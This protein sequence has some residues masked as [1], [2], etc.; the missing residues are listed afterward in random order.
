MA[1]A[2]GNMILISSYIEPSGLILD[3]FL[4]T[5]NS[6]EFAIQITES[7]YE[8]RYD[9]PEVVFESFSALSDMNVLSV[10]LSGQAGDPLCGLQLILKDSDN[11]VEILDGL[12][13]ATG[14]MHMSPGGSMVSGPTID[15]PFIIKKGGTYGNSIV[16]VNSLNARYTSSFLMTTVNISVE[17]DQKT[18][19]VRD[20]VPTRFR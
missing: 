12:D 5:A 13:G 11:E 9:V 7:E 15:V 19:I 18:I 16:L 17:I 4:I 14:T 8:R 10:Q 2:N 20:E 6:N 1:A 3:K